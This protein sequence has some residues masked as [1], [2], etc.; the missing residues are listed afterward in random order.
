MFVMKT[1][2]VRVICNGNSWT[3]K[4]RDMNSFMSKYCEFTL[5]NFF[6]TTSACVMRRKTAEDVFIKYL[7]PR[8]NKIE[9]IFELCRS[10]PLFLSRFFISHSINIYISNRRFS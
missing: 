6:L 10:L 4:I 2:F 1:G 9:A 3:K 5:Y 7:H 8:D